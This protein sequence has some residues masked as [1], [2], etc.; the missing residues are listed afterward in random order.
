MTI[1]FISFHTYVK[2]AYIKSII[3]FI[4]MGEEQYNSYMFL[5][6]VGYV[7]DDKHVYVLLYR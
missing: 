5:F 2:S 3:P 6:Y 7:F 4:G 1:D